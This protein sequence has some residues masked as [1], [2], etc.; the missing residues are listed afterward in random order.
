M[1][2]QVAK[3]FVKYSS[4][5]VVMVRGYKPVSNKQKPTTA[6]KGSRLEINKAIGNIILKAD[7][8]ERKTIGKLL[9]GDYFEDWDSDS[10][11]VIK[12]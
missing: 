1:E 9:V 6:I 10:K 8:T 4:K 12:Y 7:K 11:Q 5:E 3:I 2:K